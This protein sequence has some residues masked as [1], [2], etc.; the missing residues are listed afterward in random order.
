MRRPTVLTITEYEG[1]SISKQ[2]SCYDVNSDQCQSCDKLY[3]DTWGNTAVYEFDRR[4][5][6]S[7]VTE[8][9]GDFRTPGYKYPDHKKKAQIHPDLGEIHDMVITIKTELSRELAT[10]GLKVKQKET[11]E[12]LVGAVSRVIK[13]RR[14]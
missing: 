12:T 8:Y 5:N 7:E 4:G 10:V 11:L 13:P 14:S 6:L 1:G 2:P 9:E 3:V